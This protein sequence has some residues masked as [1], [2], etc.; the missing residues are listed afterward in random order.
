[1]PLA[2]AIWRCCLTEI[3]IWFALKQAIKPTDI[4]KIQPKQCED[5]SLRKLYERVDRTYWAKGRVLWWFLGNVVNN[6]KVRHP[7][8]DYNKLDWNVYTCLTQL[9]DG[10]DMHIIYYI[11]NNYMFWHFSLAIFRLIN[12]KT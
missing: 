12:E 3:L 10:R 9:Y 2:A 7:R 4:L 1:M 8:C 6:H 11:K 5:G